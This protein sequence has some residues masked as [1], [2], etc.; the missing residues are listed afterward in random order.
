[1]AVSVIEQKPLFQTFPVGQE[2]IFVVSND[3][4][5]ANQ[6]KVKFCVDIHI[7]DSGLPNL[8]TT[9]DLIGTFKT[10]PNDAGVGIFDLTNILSNYVKADHL[11]ATNAQYKTAVASGSDL[12]PM[13]LIDKY[14]LSDN[15]VRYM[16]ARFY[17]EYLQSG[18]VTANPNTEVDSRDYSFFNGYLK[19]TDVLDLTAPDFGY[20]LSLFKANSSSYTLRKY[21]TNA[22]DTQ[23]ANSGDYGTL[24]FLA[25]GQAVANNVNRIR[26]Q[27]F[28]TSNSLLGTDNLTKSNT[29]GAYS[30]YTASINKKIVYIGCFPGNLENWSATYT[31]VKPNLS[32]YTIEAHDTVPG[33][34]TQTL[35]TMTIYV[36]CPD[37][38]NY[39]P[40]R[41]CW[42]NQWGAWD[43]YTFTKKSIRTTSTQGTTYT[44]LG[45]TWNKSR[46]TIDSYKG[47]KKSFRVN[48]NESIRVNTDFVSEDFNTMF[49]EMINSPEVYM[50][51][52][53]TTEP[54]NAAL[55]QYVTPVRITSTSFQKKTRANDNLI[56]YTFEI[57]KSKT[58]RTQSI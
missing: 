55:N 12:F 38:K 9:S 44:Q 46:Y 36:N 21:L 25:T 10:T 34:G 28:D 39:E 52:K 3:T 45:G 47:G 16:A 29:N 27:Y 22:P 4:A 31:T 11:C 30:T 24:A 17:V 41:L 43:Y 50:L 49:E 1:M 18:V 20:D 2:I 51:D 35:R 32:Y 19:Y 23:Y 7:S 54:T 13:H 53:Y 14:S 57:E 26:I 42:L 8:N 37:L 33:V 6:T 48:A 56:Q 15:A 5:V 58:L 40:I